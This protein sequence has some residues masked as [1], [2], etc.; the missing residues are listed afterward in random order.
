MKSKKK[1][2]QP[3]FSTFLI[4]TKCVLSESNVGDNNFETG[5]DF[6]DWW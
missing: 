1:Y 6:V 2:Y 3:E 5:G 4:E